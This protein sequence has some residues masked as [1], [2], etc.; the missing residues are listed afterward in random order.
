MLCLADTNAN[1]D[2]IDY[3]IPGND[4]AIRSIEY[5]SS[6][7]ADAVLEGKALRENKANTNS[8]A[9]AVSAKDAN[10]DEKE[11]QTSEVEK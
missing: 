2:G 1:P 3:I 5:V 10:I 11:T 7:I 6:K 9:K 8:N 4:D